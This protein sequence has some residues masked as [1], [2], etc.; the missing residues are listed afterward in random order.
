M[1]EIVDRL[2]AADQLG[3]SQVPGKYCRVMHRGHSQIMLVG[4]CLLLT[5]QQFRCLLGCL[6]HHLL[7]CNEVKTLHVVF[8]RLLI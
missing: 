5:G 4:R 6:G 7:L 1:E 3:G 2:R 8:A